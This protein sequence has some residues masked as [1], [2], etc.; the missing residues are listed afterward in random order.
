MTAYEDYG[1]LSKASDAGF[2]LHFTKPADPAEVLDQLN[3]SVRKQAG[4]RAAARAADGLADDLLAELDESA[5]LADPEPPADRRP[6]AGLG[7]WVLVAVAVL[8][9][10]VVVTLCV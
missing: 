9:A 10:A 4:E 2:D 8:A 1:H 5:D 7:V 3:D 6:G